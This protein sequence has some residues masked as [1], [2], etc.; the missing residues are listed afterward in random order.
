MAASCRA[1][2]MLVASTCR[3][4]V[5]AAASAAQAGLSVASSGLVAE[6][7]GLLHAAVLRRELLS[8][9]SGD[10]KLTRRLKRK[11]EEIHHVGPVRGEGRMLCFPL[12][13]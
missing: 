12:G 5:A 10:Q 13:L 8:S 4:Q 9:L 3:P 6:A 11:Y 2:S 7:A 1:Y